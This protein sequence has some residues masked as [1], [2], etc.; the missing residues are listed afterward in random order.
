[1]RLLFVKP[2]LVW[3]RSSGH[4]VQCYYM[5]K[6]LADEGAEVSL[7]TVDPTDP[8]AV[9]GIRLAHCVQLDRTLPI[10]ANASSL[11]Y[12]QERF[13]SFWGIDKRHIHSV[14]RLANEWRADVVIAF[15]LPALPFLGAVDSAVRVWGMADEWIYHHL[16]LVRPSDRATWHHVKSAAIKGLYERAYAPL[17]DRAWA[18]SDTDRRAA[19]WLAGFRVVDLLPNGVDTDFYRPLDEPVTPN[20]A[21][22]WGRLDFEPNI[23]ALTWFL[24]R[25]WNDVLREVP[26]ARFTIVG[27]GLTDAVRRL[28]E[29]PRVT[30]RP[31]VDDLRATVCQHAVVVL[32]MISGAG[33]KNK[34]L[35][36]AAMGRPIICTPRAALDLKPAN[37]L[38]FLQA[39]GQTEWVKGLVSLWNDETHRQALG[40]AARAWVSEYHSWAAPARN[41]LAAFQEAIDARRME[42]R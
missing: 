13:R 16:S 2:A 29:L 7:A 38:P 37:Q 42:K 36:G 41:A 40:R 39:R 34:L 24:T 26:D 22:F 10:D 8:R 14:R 33:I 30:L 35:E 1:M 5:M 27:Y 20:T 23:D 31:N 4:D 12:L 9:E 18:V 19:S 25:V 17:V 6:A 28:A 21:V 11:T 3:P 15:G 32:P